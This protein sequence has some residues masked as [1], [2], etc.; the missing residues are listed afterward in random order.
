[1]ISAAQAHHRLVARGDLRLAA[2]RIELRAI[3]AV[4]Q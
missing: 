3:A 1:M 4:T 2:Q